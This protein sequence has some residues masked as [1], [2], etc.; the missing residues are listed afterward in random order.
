M[1]NSINNQ[2]DHFTTRKNVSVQPMSA[3]VRDNQLTAVDNSTSVDSRLKNEPVSFDNT[4]AYLYLKI[5]NTWQLCHTPKRKI[6][7]IIDHDSELDDGEKYF[8]PSNEKKTFPCSELKT[9]HV[10]ELPC[11]ELANYNRF[12]TV[13]GGASVTQSRFNEL[14]ACAL[15]H[16][17]LLTVQER[18]SSASVIQD[19]QKESSHPKTTTHNTS[20]QDVR[21]CNNTVK[22]HAINSQATQS[23]EEKKETSGEGNNNGENIVSDLSA[24]KKSSYVI[25]SDQQIM[26]FINECHNQSRETVI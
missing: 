23:C 6:S 25:L 2:P 10:S 3:T 22:S 11:S 19:I 9:R 24:N 7:T 18:D 13:G 15:P 5:H 21:S 20:V 8:I 14:D 1:E 17:Q 4:Y 26:Q 12:A 16:L